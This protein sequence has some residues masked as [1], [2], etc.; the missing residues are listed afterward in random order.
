V[1]VWGYA[2][3]G[4]GFV[5][6]CLATL[7]PLF[8]RTLRLGV[9]STA[10][11]GDDT[12]HGGFEMLRRKNRHPDEIPDSRGVSNKSQCQGPRSTSEESLVQ[13]MKAKGIYV[14]RSLFQSSDNG[15]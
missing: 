3:V 7:R 14:R 13:D 6:S 8:K 5:V 15:L 1:V 12:D 11:M 9:G 4:M 2:E 10:N